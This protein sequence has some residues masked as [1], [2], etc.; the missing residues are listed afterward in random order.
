MCLKDC[1][2]VVKYQTFHRD[3]HFLYIILELMD[4]SLDELVCLEEYHLD[5]CTDVVS[6]IAFLHNNGVILRD[7]K[8]WNI[9]YKEQPDRIHLKLADFGLSKKLSLALPHGLPTVMHS[10]AYTR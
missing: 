9:L 1:E 6:G 3:E 4:G 8:P 5:L 7:I 10:K 2:Q